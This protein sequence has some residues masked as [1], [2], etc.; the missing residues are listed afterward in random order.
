[1]SVRDE[2]LTWIVDQLAELGPVHV[3]RMFGAAGLYFDGRIFGIVD[4]DVVY[5]K[6]GDENRLDYVERGMEAFR[7]TPGE[8][9]MS[10]F[11]VPG[12]VLED[13][14]ELAEWARKACAAGAAAPKKRAASASR[15]PARGSRR[16]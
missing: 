9:S 5:F 2:Q 15:K 4:D 16:S 12:D 6:V 7:P 13:S 8:V 10:Y 1:M 14:G 3:R 11:E